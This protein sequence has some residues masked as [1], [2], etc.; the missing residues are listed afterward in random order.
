MI[1]P[2][3]HRFYAMFLL[4]SLGGTSWDV[5]FRSL[6]S[7]LYRLDASLSRICR[8]GTMPHSF[9]RRS[10]CLRAWIISPTVLFF[11]ASAQIDPESTSTS[12]IVYFLPQ[13][14]TTGNLPV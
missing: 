6:I 9:M 12:K 4:W 2:C 11:V 14:E 13:L 1:L 5:V 8:F 10:V 7:C 3:L